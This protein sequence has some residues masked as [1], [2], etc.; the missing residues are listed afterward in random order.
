MGAI[1]GRTDAQKEFEV[2]TRPSSRQSEN[3]STGFERREI[4]EIFTV[5]GTPTG[6]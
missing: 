2:E 3:K 1:M 5:R 6:A 4:S